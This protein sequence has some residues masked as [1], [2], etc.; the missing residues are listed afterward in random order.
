MRN[1]LPSW[2]A[3]PETATR[4]R[5]RMEVVFDYAIASQWRVDNPA[6]AVSKVLPRSRGKKEHHPA[7]AYG[8]L[9][10]FIQALRTSTADTV[11]RLGLEF[12]VLSAARTGEVRFMEWG[13][14]DTEAATWTVPA[15]RMKVRKE[16]R[17]PLSTRALAVLEEARSLGTGSGLVFPSQ[18]R[19]PLSDMAFTMVLRRLNDGDAVPH[20]FR[21]TFKDW[22]WATHC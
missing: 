14:V 5:Q 16:H 18:K 1:S 22:T 19:K 17:V 12:L 7:M 15:P 10:A 8:K 3:K 6:V 9:P 13:E 2:N 20:G 4:V 11:T 21:S